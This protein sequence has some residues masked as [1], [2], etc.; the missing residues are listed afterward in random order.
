MKIK[1][2]FFF[3]I[4]GLI[5]GVGCI[6]FAIGNVFSND[7]NVVLVLV[8][9]FLFLFGLTF[10]TT[11][12][13]IIDK[14]KASLVEVNIVLG[15]TFKTKI[16]LANYCYITILRQL[17]SLKSRSRA[18]LNFDNKTYAFKYDVILINKHH[19]NKYKIKSLN[20]IEQANE[21]ASSLSDYLNFEIVK[22][23]P[24]RRK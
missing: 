23:N 8:S 11:K 24:K 14:E 10:F 3:P 9:S 20:N 2:G 19:H 1:Q 5:C 18:T 15:L 13:V 6:A 16:N 21:L 7:L 17:Y 4:G 22:F 12:S